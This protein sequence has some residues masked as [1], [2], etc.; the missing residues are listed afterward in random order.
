MSFQRWWK[1]KTG[2]D[3][4][5]IASVVDLGVEPEKRSK[6]SSGVEREKKTHA[7]GGI[8]TDAE[9]MKYFGHL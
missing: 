6:E 7:Q 2:E 9:R 5:T 1:A 4:G 3:L 8:L